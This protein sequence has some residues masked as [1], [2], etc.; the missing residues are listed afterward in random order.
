MTQPAYYVPFASYPMFAFFFDLVAFSLPGLPAHALNLSQRQ[1]V[2]ASRP[3]IW[4]DRDILYIVHTTKDGK[5]EKDKK[6]VRMNA[7]PL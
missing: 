7:L 2:P 5:I 1:N 3:C 4:I 6:L